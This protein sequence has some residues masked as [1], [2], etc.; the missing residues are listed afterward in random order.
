MAKD[1]ATIVRD[2]PGISLDLSRAQLGDFDR[3]RVVG[4]FH[5]LGF[6][7]MLDDIARSMGSHGSDAMPTRRR[8][9]PACDVR[10]GRR[11]GRGSGA[12]G[13]APTRPA[14]AQEGDGIVRDLAALDAVVAQLKAAEQRRVQRPDHRPAADAGRHRRDRAGDRARTLAGTSRSAT[15]R[16]RSRSSSSTGP[17]SAS[18]W[19]RCCATPASRSGPTTPSSTRSCWPA[20][21]SRPRGWRSTR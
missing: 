12:S 3:Q 4:L 6:R 19:R 9:R 18:G 8:Q 5:E 15:S 21:A 17:T 2:V 1:L 7:R 10:G 16:R 11:R 20:T 14:V 13:C